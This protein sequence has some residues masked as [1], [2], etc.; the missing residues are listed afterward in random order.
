MTIQWIQMRGQNSARM[1]KVLALYDR[2]FPLEVRE[3]HDVFYS[4]FQYAQTAAPNQFC[5]LIGV[6]GDQLLSFAA[7]HFLAEVNT[8]FVVYIAADPNH[9]NRG[10]GSKTLAKMEDVFNEAAILAGKSKV[11][12]IILETEKEEEAVTTMEEMEC[13]KRMHFLP[14]TNTNPVLV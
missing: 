14:K 12:G 8:G 10:M 13:R 11:S 1:D 3:P 4:G 7:G 2:S 6:E 9:R 5:L